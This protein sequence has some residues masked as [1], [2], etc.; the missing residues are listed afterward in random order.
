MMN[1]LCLAL[2]WALSLSNVHA[3]R[4]STGNQPEEYNVDA[5]KTYDADFMKDMAS[6]CRPEHDGYF[7]S[8]FGGQAR[9]Q[10]GFR[11]ETKPLSSIED[12]LDLVEDKIVDGVLSNSFPDICGFTR[13][14]LFAS[15]REIRATGFRFLKIHEKSKCQIAS[16]ESRTSP[17][18]KFSH[19]LSICCHLIQESA[20]RK[21]AP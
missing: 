8:T 13:R 20:V 14:R 12:M 6:S 17:Q 15:Y 3:T 11:L 21:R 7:G 10:Y 1:R 2:L 16:G 19:V 4:H 5:Q 18:Y 9:L